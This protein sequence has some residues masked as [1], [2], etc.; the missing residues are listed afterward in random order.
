MASWVFLGGHGVL[1]I[2]R[3]A[4]LFGYFLVVMAFW[5]FLGCHGVL[6]ISRLSW[7]FGY[8]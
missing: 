8:F 5:V 4:W 2:S 1:G 6:G 7:R 3:W